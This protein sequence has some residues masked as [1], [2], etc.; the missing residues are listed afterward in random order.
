MELD[1]VNLNFVL[2]ALSDQIKSKNWDVTNPDEKAHLK[3]V[4]NLHED[5]LSYLDGSSSAVERVTK[6]VNG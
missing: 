5:I 6:W 3:A 4:M 2:E 1:E